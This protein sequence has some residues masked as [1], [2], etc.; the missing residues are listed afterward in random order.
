MVGEAER[1]E[2]TVHAIQ[3]VHVAFTLVRIG[4]LLALNKEALFQQRLQPWRPPVVLL[5]RTS[6]TLFRSQSS[7]SVRTMKMTKPRKITL[8]IEEKTQ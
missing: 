5:I 3:A 8:R 6:S 4:M 2:R 7:I 1:A